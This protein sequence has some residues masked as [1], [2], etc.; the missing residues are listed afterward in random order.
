MKN[1]G[2]IFKICGNR[3]IAAHVGAKV[4]HLDS[5]SI[6]PQCEN[7][8]ECENRNILSDRGRFYYASIRS[9]S[10]PFSGCFFPHLE[11]GSIKPQ[12]ENLQEC[13][14]RNI[15][16]DGGLFYYASIRSLLLPF[17]GCFFHISNA[18]FR[19]STMNGQHYSRKKQRC[20]AHLVTSCIMSIRDV[21]VT[22]NRS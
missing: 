18:I 1:Y 4:P 21:T 16:S 2:N 22:K 11:S 7:L 5:G 14:N 17:S 15:L 8:Q 6:K 10:L 19:R 12:F 20:A 9:L 3:D 13:E